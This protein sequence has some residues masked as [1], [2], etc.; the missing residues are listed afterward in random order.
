MNEIVPNFTI[1]FMGAINLNEYGYVSVNVTR[2]GKSFLWELLLV[3]W[4]F[5]GVM[6]KYLKSCLEFERKS[7]GIN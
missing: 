7:K 4:K 1:G 3:S 6:R 5:N 2:I